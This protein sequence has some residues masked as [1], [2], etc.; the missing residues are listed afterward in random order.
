M[1]PQSTS[2]VAVTDID[3]LKDISRIIVSNLSHTE[4]IV[5]ILRED[6]KEY[7]KLIAKLSFSPKNDVESVNNILLELAD[8]QS[9]ESRITTIVKIMSSVVSQ[10]EL[11][12]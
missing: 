8:L 6:M 3:K 2:R 5:T 11:D 12:L 10:N 1:E 7:R 4:E 9:S